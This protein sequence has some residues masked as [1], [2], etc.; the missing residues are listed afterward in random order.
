MYT[1][2]ELIAGLKER[3][4]N[5]M[6][7]LYAN[8][9]PMIRDLIQKNGGSEDDASDIFQDG[10]VVLYQK[11]QDPQFSW[12]STLKTFLYAVCKNKWLMHLRKKRNKAMVD[13]DDNVEIM[14]TLNV[15]NELIMHE[16]KE[17]MRLHFGQLG[18]DCQ[19]VLRRFFDGDSLRQIAEVM[20]FTEAYAKKRKFICQ[21]K[22]IAAISAD[23]IYNELSA[24]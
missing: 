8:Y 12:T 5:V 20:N 17:L 2:L 21:Q 16:K 4:L 11:S 23:P 10:M 15:Q 14:T 24:S 7:H 1:E 22:L 19:E 3:D 18:S 6:K 9:Y 13:L